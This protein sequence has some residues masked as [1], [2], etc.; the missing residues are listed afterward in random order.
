MFGSTQAGGNLFGQASNTQSQPGG[1]L[2]ANLGASRPQQTGGIFAGLGQNTQQ[3][4]PQSTGVFGNLGQSTQQN[5]QQ[6]QG[7]GVFGNLGQSTQQPQQQ[8]QG[9]G[10]F[11]NFGQSTQQTQQQPQQ[12]GGLFSSLASSQQNQQRPGIFTQSTQQN[13]PQLG[14]SQLG[15]SLWQPNSGVAPREKSIPEQIATVL[16]K[17]DTGNPNCAFQHYFYNKVDDSMVPFYRAG[18]G[19][20]PKAWEE[21]FSKKPGPG[22]IPVLCV[23]FAQLGERIKTQQRSLAGYNARL[24]EINNSLNLMLQNHNTKTSIRAMDARRKHNVLKQRCLALA[25]KV[26]VLRNRGYA[27]GG[28]EEDLKTKLQALE[29]G[30]SDPGLGA[31]G[32]EIWAR[33]LTVQERAKLLKAEIEKSGAD[34][35]QGLDDEMNQQAK[36]ILE[37]YQTQLNHL[38]KELEAVQKDY[39]EWEKE[40]GP[41]PT[42][43]KRDD[44]SA[45]AE[46][47]RAEKTAFM[48][49]KTTSLP[50][51]FVPYS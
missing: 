35:P 15:G 49:H 37:D 34:N 36:Q 1:G 42:K 13:L 26:Q 5:Q 51:G 28:D 43:I 11:G 20:D 17:W 40:H 27:M 22:F 24:H 50:S 31:R 33:M 10:M 16:Q 21:A 48:R 47:E 25:T 18:P 14:Q 3:T 4:N 8:S 44:A 19:E 29:R 9:G 30:V 23:G 39:M 46:A 12:T 38:K 2:F 41:E 7:G 6:Q 45:K 32:E